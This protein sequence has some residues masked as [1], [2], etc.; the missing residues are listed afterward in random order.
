MNNSVRLWTW[1]SPLIA[2]GLVLGCVAVCPAEAEPAARA[3]SRSLAP[4]VM[5]TIVPEPRVSESVDRHPIVELLAVKPNLK[6]AQETVFRRDIWHLEFKFKPVR[7]IW[8]DVPQ[9]SGR[10]QRKLIW[11]LVYSVTNPGKALHP[12]QDTNGTYKV[13][14]IDKPIRFIPEF[15]LHAPEFDKAYPDRV[16]PLATP[17]IGRREDAARESRGEF[18]NSVT[19][20]KD[21]IQV[22]QTVW[23]IATWES[24][25]PRIDRFSI[26]VTGLTNAYRW[27]D[28]PGAYTPGATIGTG[29]RLSR[30]I[31]KLNFWRPGDEFDQNEKEI[32]YGIPGEVDYEWLYR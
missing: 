31:L 1:Y 11:Y 13:E 20:A 29:R 4:G 14:T 26:Y 15:L 5:K 25:D 27:S 32:R 23:G 24:I 16:I 21:E 18:L 17:G 8:I 19:M 22:G 12:V 9:P 28:E 3:P 7:F 30:E 6:M 10:M 2:A